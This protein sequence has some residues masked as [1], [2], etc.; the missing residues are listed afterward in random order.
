MVG[1]TE[2][3]CWENKILA[4]QMA[5]NIEIP[6]MYC[7]Y[8]SEIGRFFAYYSHTVRMGFA[9]QIIWRN[10][11]KATASPHQSHS[12]RL[13]EVVPPEKRKEFKSRGAEAERDLAFW[14]EKRNGQWILSIF[15]DSQ[16]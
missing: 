11:G 8:Q 10:G 6:N 15:A 7:R 2:I 4:V 16:N 3:S 9:Y 5:G 1:N 12:F 13:P 14:L